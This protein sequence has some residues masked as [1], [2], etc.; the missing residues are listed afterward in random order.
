M[1]WLEGIATWLIW[2]FKSGEP[3]R[4]ACDFPDLDD[5]KV[6]CMALFI[7]C[8]SFR[9]ATFNAVLICEEVKAGAYLKNTVNYREYLIDFSL[10]Y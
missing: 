3:D 1:Q 10:V 4:Q 5:P 2:Y 9:D 6:Y 7:T 8:D